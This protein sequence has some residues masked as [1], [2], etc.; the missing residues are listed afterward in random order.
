MKYSDQEH[1]QK[2]MITVLIYHFRMSHT[3]AYPK[4]LCRL[5]YCRIRLNDIICDLNRPL[6]DIFLQGKIPRN[7]G[8][9]VIRN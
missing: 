9:I 5:P 1:V 2:Y 3:L 4:F 7:I 8:L 6:L